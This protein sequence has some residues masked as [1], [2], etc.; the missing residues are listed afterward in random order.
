LRVAAEE[1]ASRDPSIA[2]FAAYEIATATLNTAR[3]FAQD[4]RSV[5]EA[6]VDHV[7]RCFFNRFAKGTVPCS[8][9]AASEV[10]LAAEAPTKAV[11]VVCD[12]D[13]VARALAAQTTQ[14]DRNR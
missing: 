14:S 5:T 10:P 12:E 1:I 4:K 6:C 9:S 13:A 11:D 8:L 7:M 2:Y 3:Y